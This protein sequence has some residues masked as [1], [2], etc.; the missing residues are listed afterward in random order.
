MPRSKQLNLYEQIRSEVEGQLDNE[1]WSKVPLD[2][3]M[4]E[5]I[6]LDDAQLNEEYTKY[7][8]DLAYWNARYVKAL[9]SYMLAKFIYEK[10]RARLW[11]EIRED[12]KAEGDRLT[13]DDLKCEVRMRDEYEQAHL[14]LIE[15][16]AEKER[17]RKFAESLTAKRDML[18][19][20]GAKLRAELE[21]DP[22]LRKYT[23]EL[24]RR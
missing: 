19:S 3:E 7:S 20:F 4:L 18:Q 24:N 14:A 2:N 23:R 6:D 15:A 10:T 17:M 1:R 16:E 11:L 21:G 22:S 8:G 5:V 9:R 12:A 13:A